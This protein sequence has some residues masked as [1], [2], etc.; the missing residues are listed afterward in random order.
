MENKNSFN[1][2][3]DQKWI[4]DKLPDDIAWKLIKH[5][6]SYVS[7]ERPTTDDLI[8]NIA[9]ESIKQTLKRDLKKRKEKC[10]KNSENWKKGWRPKDNFENSNKANGYFENPTKAKKADRDSDSDRDSERDIIKEKTEFEKTFD[11]FK[12]MRKKMKSE[13]TDNAI[14]LL[15]NKLDKMSG[16]NEDIKIQLLEQSIM[17]GRKSVYELK[18]VDIKDYTDM[19]IFDWEIKK[20]Y[21]W[22]KAKVGKEKFFELKSKWIERASLNNKL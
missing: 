17:N 6:F 21:Q 3:V 22:L 19:A 14:K 8:I 15:N 10:E 16:G 7:D 11:E 18:W 4:F 20:D 5:I 13:M 2:Y 9:F 12:K 1:M